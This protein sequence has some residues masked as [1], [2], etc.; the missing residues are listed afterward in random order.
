M[1]QFKPPA[2]HCFRNENCLAAVQATVGLGD[3]DDRGERLLLLF[4]RADVVKQVLDQI[5][6]KF[7]LSDVRRARALQQVVAEFVR[8]AVERCVRD[9]QL[10]ENGSPIERF[11]FAWVEG[12]VGKQSEG[13]DA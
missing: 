1:L 9:A 3:L 5:A 10:V 8:D 13:D 12:T 2:A 11:D 7:D 4:R 6:I